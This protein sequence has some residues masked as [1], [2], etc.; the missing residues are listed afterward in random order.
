MRVVVAFGLCVMLMSLFAGQRGLPAVWAA[1]RQAA[2]LARE[3][4]MLKAENATLRERA[5]AL[6]D[7]RGTIE[8]AAREALGLA[9]RGE[10]V[11]RRR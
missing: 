2:A 11:V 10:L 4:G 3:I 6:R 1:R 9:R 8:I 5:Q 7:D